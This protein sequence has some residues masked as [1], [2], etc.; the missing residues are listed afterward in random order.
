MSVNPCDRAE[1]FISCD[2]QM[3]RYY[4]FEIDPQ[5]KTMDYSCSFYRKYDYP[6]SGEQ[7]VQARPVEGGYHVEAAFSCDY[8]RRLG[9]LQ[10]DGSL[11]IGF[12]RG[13]AVRPGEITWYSAVNPGTPEP[14][15]HV[16][17]SLF[18]LK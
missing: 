6:W 10:D 5:G 4:C 15:F 3:Q 13:D 14:D 17:E 16:P 9:L 12:Y 1:V 8:L 2:P 18:I 7:N 11:L